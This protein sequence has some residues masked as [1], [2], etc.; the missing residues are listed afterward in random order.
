MCFS[1][2]EGSIIS[3]LIHILNQSLLAFNWLLN[4]QFVYICEQQALVNHFLNV[5]SKLW[6]RSL[7]NS[8]CEYKPSALLMWCISLSPV[9]SN[10]FCAY[11]S[12]IACFSC[13]LCRSFYNKK[14]KES[15]AITI[16][17]RKW[18]WTTKWKWQWWWRI[19]FTCSEEEIIDSENEEEIID[20]D[21]DNEQV[22]GHQILPRARDN[23]EV[24]WGKGK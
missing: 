8:C 3:Y 12:Y 7:R 16:T 13:T 19:H 20:S 11:E 9:S 10:T 18:R 2:F 21:T 22:N 24:K 17:F 1:K 14:S 6:Y 15:N 5:F 4:F 23:A